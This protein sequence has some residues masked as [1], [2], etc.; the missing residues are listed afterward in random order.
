M[1]KLA[2]KAGEVDTGSSVTGIKSWTLDYTVDALETTDFS[3]AGVK[4][5]IVGGSG[6]SGSFEGFKD[7]A[8]Q[9]LAGAS[10]SLSLKESQTASQKWTGTAFI[11]GIHPSTASDG[12]VSISYDFQGTGALTVATG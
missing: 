9:G 1:A 7:G 10:I 8:P 5:F 11:T 12:V 4:S 6:W 3:V 2:G